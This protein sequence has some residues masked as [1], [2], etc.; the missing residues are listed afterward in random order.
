MID[1]IK[2]FF[3]AITEPQQ[4]HSEDSHDLAISALLCEVCKADHHIAKEE[5]AVIEKTLT[6]LL[7]VDTAQAKA[8]LEIG[9]EKATLSNSLFDF[10]TQLQGLDYDVR[11]NIIKAMWEVAYADN[12]L[13]P[14]EELIIRKASD[15]IYVGHSEFIKT[16]LSV[17]NSLPQVTL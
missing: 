13:D 12:S 15:L 7:N 2:A 14:I 16:K 9:K 11:C 4:I 6:K 1:S 3:N 17:I 5:E 10:T 8:L